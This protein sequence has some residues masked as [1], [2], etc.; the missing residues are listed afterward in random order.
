M[1]SSRIEAGQFQ[2]SK[3]LG[4]F[5]ARGLMKNNNF[6]R[7]FLLNNTTPKV[8]GAR[9]LWLNLGLIRRL[10]NAHVLSWGAIGNV[11]LPYWNHYTLVLGARMLITC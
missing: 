2:Q 8:R 4:I 11:F 5:L 6:S 10:D 7:S 3:A 1:C 9:A